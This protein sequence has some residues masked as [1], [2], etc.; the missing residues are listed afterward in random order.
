MAVPFRR[1]SSKKKKLRHTVS[2]LNFQKRAT[3]TLIKC[4]NCQQV[5]KPHWICSTCLTYRSVKL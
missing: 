3:S 5:K 2:N 4:N 1:T